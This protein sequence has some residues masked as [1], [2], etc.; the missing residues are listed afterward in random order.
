MR[1]IVV[2]QIFNHSALLLDASHSAGVLG[3]V[4]VDCPDCAIGGRYID[5][6]D[7]RLL[8]S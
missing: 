7:I 2:C 3:I 1:F 6:R 5:N 8:C 4:G